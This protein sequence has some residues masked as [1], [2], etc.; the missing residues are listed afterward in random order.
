M[1]EKTLPLSSLATSQR[2]KSIHSFQI[3]N[4]LEV[5]VDITDNPLNLSPAVL[6]QMAA[7]INKK[8]S[9]LFVSKILGKHLPVNPHIAL[10]GGASLGILYCQKLGCQ[11][12]F[13]ISDM[14]EAFQDSKRAKNL[15]ELL[16]L[17]P[18][19]LHDPT[20]FIGFAETATALGQSMFDV[21]RGPIQ[22]LHT[23]R[24]FVKGVEPV[25]SFEEEHSHATAHRCYPLDEDF[26]R[27]PESIVL[28]DDEITTGKTALNIIRAL[29]RRRSHSNYVL[30]SLLDWRSEADI[31]KFAQLER[32]LGI[33][34]TC[35]S[36]M[37]GKIHVTGSPGECETAELCPSVLGKGRVEHLFVG[38]YFEYISHK[39]VDSSGEENPMR[40]LKATGRFGVEG[41]YIPNM[42]EQIMK[43]G[44]Y[45]QSK[46]K[47]KRT[48]C[49][50]SGEFMYIPMR[51]AAAMGEGVSYQSSTRSPIFP[52]TGEGYAI[53]NGFPFTSHEDSAIPNFFYNIQTDE[54]DEVFVFVERV[55]NLAA[56]S[57]YLEAVQR[58][59]IPNIHFVHFAK[60]A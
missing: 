57:S 3:L 10:L 31:E 30:A 12:P 13:G 49:M 9:F 48:L 28:V 52:Y 23:T 35:L 55:N 6:F 1:K 20:L 5:T 60:E 38:G 14:V 34:I 36:L 7:R 8:R 37:K 2:N 58:T 25:I 43:C 40:Y 59:S 32:E 4:D 16:K 46:R 27:G 42:D 56:L 45:L 29:H 44:Q 47:G 19:Q 54:Y 51:I 53:Q 33:T 15:Y 11:T 17:S 26:F 18:L 50:G 24:D 21:F 22:Y 39:S 41:A